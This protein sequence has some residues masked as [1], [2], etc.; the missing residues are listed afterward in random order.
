M[1]EIKFRA[2]ELPSDYVLSMG[3]KP[4]MVYGTGFLKD[5]VN[6]WLVVND[7]M[8]P[9]AFGETHYIINPKTV[10][11]FTGLHDKNGKEIYEGDKI[12]VVFL[13]NELNLE[14]KREFISTIVF[15]DH[16]GCYIFSEYHNCSFDDIREDLDEMYSLE[17]I[18]NIHEA[19]K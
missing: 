4:K 17:V 14:I 16:R 18:G 5:L 9:I 13:W 11:Q 2:M 1:R 19:T 15:S 12:K 6:T 7:E 8:K 10:G 3:Y